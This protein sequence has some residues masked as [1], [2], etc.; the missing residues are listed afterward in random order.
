VGDEVDPYDEDAETTGGRRSTRLRGIPHSKLELET[1]GN[2]YRSSGEHR[3][4]S[5][6]SM[7]RKGEMTASSPGVRVHA[8]RGRGRTEAAR[9]RRRAV[10][11]ITTIPRLE[12]VLACFTGRGCS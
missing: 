8:R 4:P 1:M 5:Q 6:N 12:G 9:F 2:T 7:E 3:I 10:R 11:K